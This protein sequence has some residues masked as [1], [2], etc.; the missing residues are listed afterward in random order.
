MRAVRFIKGN[1]YH[2]Y[3]R[4]V[5]KRII[6]EENLDYLRFLFSM[7]IHQSNIP[8]VKPNRYISE[9]FKTYRKG[10]ALRSDQILDGR[11]RRQ[12]S[13]VRLTA[14]TAFALM[15]NHFHLLLQE[16]TEGGISRYMMRLQDG[17]T[18]F[19]NT[20]Y[21]RS[22]HLLQGPFQA[23]EITTNE[24]MEY[25]SAY[26][27]RNPREI[28]GWTKKEHQYPWSSYQDYL[29]ENRWEELLDTAPIF[30]QF[31]SKKEYRSFVEKSGAKKF[32]W[33]I[34]S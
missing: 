27:H 3:N 25:V 30:N 33:E 5:E 7:L 11:W 32:D 22:G 10:M 14:L 16:T 9:W 31:K 23:V 19:F 34:S 4:G 20:K 13:D 2:I 29:G 26:I 17:Y 18:K 12:L 8:I 1:F 28:K 15:P 21:E 6:F 24:Q